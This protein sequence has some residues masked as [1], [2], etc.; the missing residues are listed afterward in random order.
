MEQIKIKTVEVINFRSLRRVKYDLSD[1]SVFVG[2]ND[3][4]K[5]NI[6]KALNLFFNN[7]VDYGR[8]FIFQENY[9]QKGQV[10]K[11]A[12][13]III[14]VKFV[15]PKSYQKNGHYLV[16]EKRWR[17]D[18]S[19]N[20]PIIY[21]LEEQ[22][23][24][25]EIGNRSNVR[26]LIDR[27]NY[28]YV[29]AVRDA[30]YFESLRRRIYKMLSRV[31]QSP[32]SQASNVFEQSITKHLNEL[33]QTVKN[34]LQEDITL[35]FPHDLSQIF[36][37]LEF[38]FLETNISLNNRGDG[39]KNIYIPMILNFIAISEKR[40]TG[41]GASPYTFIW[42]YEEPENNME[43]RK[44][45]ELRDLF[46]SYVGNSISQ[47][48]L[49]SHSPVFYN[50]S[51]RSNKGEKE[52]DILSVRKNDQDETIVQ[53][54]EEDIENEMGIYKLVSESAQQLEEH[55]HDLQRQLEQ[56]NQKTG[57]CLY[58]EGKTDKMVLEKIINDFNLNDCGFCIQT[59]EQ[60]AG[61]N[62]VIDMLRAW[63]CA[64]K[65]EIDPPRAAG[66]VDEDAKNMSSTYNSAR[67]PKQITKCFVLRGKKAVMDWRG[68]NLYN[69]NTCLETYYPDKIWEE[70][71]K[72]GWLVKKENSKILNDATT[73]KCINEEKTG[74]RLLKNLPLFITHSVSS[75]GKVRMAEL[76]RSLNKN[77]LEEDFPEMLTIIRE[78][79]D[80]LNKK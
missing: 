20:D 62:Y 69:I 22:G 1:I 76:V 60:G 24:K 42:G 18:G 29:P 74:K 50:L 40:L 34:T 65:H 38:L 32:L 56:A 6:L 59:L 7:E 75:K 45:Y 63:D 39:I 78:I 46:V 43:I 14:K 70:A 25:K 3:V 19:K 21:G 37:K 61:C 55:I 26:Q 15:L 11:K 13:E 58:V 9:N 27:V 31:A 79:T 17:K 52:Y 5:S 57:P 28:I 16:C 71:F 67:S 4:G 35:S 49:T 36:E 44:C 23:K 66:L 77:Q 68:K 80:F 48:I 2:L 72:K 73:K 12:S 53:R 64:K 41:K 8:E 54:A 51:C 10:K 30:N 47:I 33:V